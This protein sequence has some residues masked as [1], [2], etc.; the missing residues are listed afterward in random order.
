[1]ILW[2]NKKCRV[3]LVSAFARRNPCGPCEL[4]LDYIKQLTMVMEMP[5][6]YFFPGFWRSRI[7]GRRHRSFPSIQSHAKGL[8]YHDSIISVLGGKC[9]LTQSTPLDNFSTEK[10][11]RTHG[12]SWKYDWKH[13]HIVSVLSQ[14]QAVQ[15]NSE[16]LWHFNRMFS[17]FSPSC[18]SLFHALFSLKFMNTWIVYSWVL[19]I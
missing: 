9:R 8:Q 17:S 12:A 4:L 13:E 15:L 1:M 2:D 3:D 6:L 18:H 10:K 19:P 5:I 14:Q 16:L 11:E 7:D